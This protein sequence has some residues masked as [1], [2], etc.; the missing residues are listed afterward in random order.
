MIKLTTKDILW[1]IL[2][3]IITYKIHDTKNIILF[4]SLLIIII[5]FT[6]S[7]MLF[8]LLFSEKITKIKIKKFLRIY[9]T[10]I[11]SEEPIEDEDIIKIFSGM[12][13]KIRKIVILSNNN[14]SPPTVIPFGKIYI[15]KMEID[16]LNKHPKFLIP[17][18]ETIR[19][20]LDEMYGSPKIFLKMI[21]KEITIT[22]ATTTI[23]TLLIKFLGV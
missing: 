19:K 3:S 9:N 1:I 6:F 2:L 22:I 4:T 18:R 5:L 13:H 14:R 15:K 8:I 21:M 12:F 17:Y 23:T 20:Y 16:F 7:L 11:Y 10:N